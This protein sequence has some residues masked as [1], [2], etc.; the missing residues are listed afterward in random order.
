MKPTDKRKLSK[1]KQVC[2]D[3][4]PISG[5]LWGTAVGRAKFWNQVVLGSNSGLVTT[6]VWPK[7][8]SELL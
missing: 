7:H 3:C 8:I 6:A 1:F 2:R 5:S 4:A